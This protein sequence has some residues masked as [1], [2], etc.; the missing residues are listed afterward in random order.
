MFLSDV[1]E[2]IDWNV[3]DHNAAHQ[4]D[5]DWLNREV[6]A[7][8]DSEPQRS[9]VVFTHHSPTLLEDANNPRHLI[10]AADVRSGFVT[11]LSAEM[12]WR[13]EAVEL[14]AFGHTHFNCDFL[15]PM[16]KKRVFANQPGYKRTEVTTFDREKILSIPVAGRKVP[17]A[18]FEETEPARSFVGQ[19]AHK[20]RQRRDI[21]GDNAACCHVL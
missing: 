3:G 12:C 10:D 13:S 5:L 1:A 21:R 9:V 20:K 18:P 17:H 11:D 2:I 15:D 7:I 16:T 4:A 14:W 19:S 6:A 8:V